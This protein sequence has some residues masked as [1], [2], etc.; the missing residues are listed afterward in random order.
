MHI[1]PNINT[2]YCGRGRKNHNILWYFRK[3]PKVVYLHTD[4]KI[5]AT[6]H[7][8]THLAIFAFITLTSSQ[9]PHQKY[10]TSG[11]QTQTFEHIQTPLSAKTHQ[12]ANEQLLKIKT[13]KKPPH[14]SVDPQHIF[15]KKHTLF[16]SIFQPVTSHTKST[17]H[18]PNKSTQSKITNNSLSLPQQPPTIQQHMFKFTYEHS[19]ICPFQSPTHAKTH[20]N[21]LSKHPHRGTF[22]PNHTPYH[23]STTPL[24]QAPSGLWLRPLDKLKFIYYNTHVNL[25]IQN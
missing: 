3:T 9:L 1:F 20:N 13:S 8:Y 24:T 14:I 22:K 25:T 23:I 18:P 15:T 12:N 6:S 2:I 10:Q 19:F 5:N 16:I 21:P 17:I 11:H 7:I 4:C